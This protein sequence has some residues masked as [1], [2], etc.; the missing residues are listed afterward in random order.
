MT[1][2]SLARR[3]SLR[4]VAAGIV[5]SATLTAACAVADAPSPQASSGDSLAASEADLR[6]GRIMFLQCR[7][8]HSTEEGGEH[9]V[10]PNLHGLFGARAGTKEGFTYSE[11]MTDSGIVWSEAALEE[12]LA[13]PTDYV[14]GTIMVFA[15][16][17]QP[18]DRRALIAFVK[19][20]VE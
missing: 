10:G 12:F 4:Q 1:R 3:A 13:R 6:R 11:A 16:I 18:A 19:S 7:A 8:C 14:P 9:R 15:G 20:Q 2:T 17:E 5:L